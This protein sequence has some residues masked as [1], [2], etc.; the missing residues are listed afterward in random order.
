VDFSNIR[1]VGAIDWAK[2]AVAG[3]AALEF[4]RHFLDRG[5]FERVGATAAE[6][7]GAHEKE[8]DR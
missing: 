7:S 6:K 4:G 5:F 2:R 8:N 1:V 3:D